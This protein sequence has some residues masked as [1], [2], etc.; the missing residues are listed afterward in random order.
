[1]LDIGREEDAGYVVFVGGEMGYWD[2]GGL[3]AVLEE[4]PDVDIAL[5]MLNTSN[6]SVG[7]AY[8]VGACAQ[9]RAITCHRDACNRYIFFGNELV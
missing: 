8:R 9:S 4:V 5:A 3:F 2:E 1:V 7:S 6:R